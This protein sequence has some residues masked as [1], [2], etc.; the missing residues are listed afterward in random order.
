MSKK[1]KKEQENTYVGHDENADQA[2][3]LFD[4]IYDF[5]EQSVNEKSFALGIDTTGL[6]LFTESSN[7]EEVLTYANDLVDALAVKAEDVI[8]VIV[9]PLCG[10]LGGTSAE[11]AKNDLL[12]LQDRIYYVNPE[13]L[14]DFIRRITSKR[15]NVFSYSVIDSIVNCFYEVEQ[16]VT[17]LEEKLALYGLPEKVIEGLIKYQPISTQEVR[18]LGVPHDIADSVFDVLYSSYDKEEI[19]HPETGVSMFLF[20]EV[21]RKCTLSLIMSIACVPLLIFGFWQHAMVLSLL[22]MSF[23]G[24]A[25]RV[26]KNTL[27]VICLLLNAILFGLSSIHLLELIFNLI[28]EYFRSVGYLR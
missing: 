24:S 14:H 2:K 23:A 3:T 4:D 20:N 11:T 13:D 16:H 18:E 5:F 12:N 28:I 19:K 6:Y 27:S 21:N 26:Y 22:G 15:D 8:I 7:E 10:R 17:P 9:D 25:K 1:K